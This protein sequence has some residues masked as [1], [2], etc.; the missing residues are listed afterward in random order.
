MP[1]T[2]TERDVVLAVATLLESTGLAAN[3]HRAAIDRAL[4]R[5]P[6]DGH[7]LAT[8]A[9]AC[10]DVAGALATADSDIADK[11]AQFD[12]IEA[13]ID[14]DLDADTV[15][16]L[17][18]FH[19]DVDNLATE[20]GVDTVGGAGALVDKVEALAAAVKQFEALA[21]ALGMPD[22]TDPADLVAA[23]VAMRGAA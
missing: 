19:D 2:A 20:L 3:H 9:D 6:L 15:K 10:V 7:H 21:A 17:Q 16:G 4:A 18:D 23:V 11:A 1:A 5:L 13:V 8:I 22:D 12:A 14:G